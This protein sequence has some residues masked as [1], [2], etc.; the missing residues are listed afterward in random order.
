MRGRFAQDLV[1]AA[2]LPI[3]LLE[4]LDALASSVDV[5]DFTPSSISA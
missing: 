5:P 3:L 2:Q 4:T 1:R